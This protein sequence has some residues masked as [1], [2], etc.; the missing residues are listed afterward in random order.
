MA[1]RLRDRVENITECIICF[2]RYSKTHVPKILRCG[3]QVCMICL[4]SIV[5]LDKSIECPEC[6]QKTQLPPEGI[7]DL[8]TNITIL[9]LAEKLAET[10]SDPSDTERQDDKEGST[11]LS[12]LAVFCVNPY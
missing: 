4:E 6:K 9:G 8:P 1:E 5:S 7:S 10:S 3:H 2:E 11:D 12:G